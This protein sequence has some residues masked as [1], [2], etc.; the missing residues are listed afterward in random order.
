[1]L[2][3]KQDKK[4]LA[5]LAKHG[6]WSPFSH[7]QLTFRIT[8]S[9]AVARQL[10]RHQVGLAVNE[11]SRRYVSDSP[12]FDL[13]LVWRSSPVKGQSKQ[14]SGDPLDDALQLEVGDFVNAFYD[15]AKGNIRASLGPGCCTRAGTDDGSTYGLAYP[16]V[17]DGQSHGVHSDLQGA[18]GRRRSS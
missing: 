13:P 3:G 5:Y 12:E 9:I 2:C 1:M 8:A 16:V 6:H 18:F 7:P 15:H 4:L 17:L 11:V 14:G 10:Y